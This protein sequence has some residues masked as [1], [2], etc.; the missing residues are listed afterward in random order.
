ME[1]LVTVAIASYNNASYI[2]RCLRSVMA[3]TYGNLEILV[4]DDGSTDNT[5]DILQSIDKDERIVVIQKENGGLSSSRQLAL[6]IAKG[7]YICFVDADDY[8]YP[9]YVECMLHKLVEDNSDV[10]ICSTKFETSEGECLKVDTEA[11]KTD[12]SISP[13]LTTPE[14]ISVNKDGVMDRLFLHDSWNKM[15]R[16]STIRHT[17]M[18]FC[19]PKGLN[20]SD[21]LF[22]MVIALHGIKYSLVSD[23]G[24]VHVIYQ[25]SAV[26]RKNKNLKKSI[27][28]IIGKMVEESKLISH[29][30][31]LR[32]YISLNYFI[33]QIAVLRDIYESCE[34][35]KSFYTEARCTRLE[36]QNFIKEMKLPKLNVRSLPFDFLMF[37]IIYN[38]NLNLIPGFFV[39]QR[40]KYK[41]KEKLYD[42]LYRGIL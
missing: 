27:D 5:I 26:H 37:H 32:E 25:S 13:I 12:T 8:L 11:F 20:G 17:N 24:Y 16:L 10:C 6:D 22:N 42:T 3:Q 30:D 40:F 31:S 1:V 9:I 29:F 34:S 41:I 14:V 23:T 36:Y 4:V 7:E 28:I 38:M 21:T 18:K 2:E 15:Y 39:Y 33:Y 35:L 19:M